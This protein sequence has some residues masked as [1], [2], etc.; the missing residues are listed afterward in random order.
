MQDGKLLAEFDIT[1]YVS[2]DRSSNRNTL[3]VKVLRWCDGS[4]LEDQVRGHDCS[5]MYA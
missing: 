4:Y 3:A 2:R 5:L 1:P